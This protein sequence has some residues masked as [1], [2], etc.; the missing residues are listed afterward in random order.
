M[1]GSSMKKALAVILVVI[2]AFAFTTS[3]LASTVSVPLGAPTW[4][5]SNNPNNQLGWDSDGVDNKIHGLPFEVMAKATGLSISIANTPVDAGMQVV[6]ASDGGNWWDQQDWQIMDYFTPSDSGE[7]GRIFI[8]L[9]DHPGLATFR[10]GTQGRIVICYWSDSWNDLDILSA[11]LTGVPADTAE[12][13][14]VATTGAVTFVALAMG[15]LAVSGGGAVIVA[16]KLR[17]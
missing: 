11:S 17:K 9:S 15:V 2:M 3:A 14:G 7:G 13:A 4:R 10:S 6:L 12:D 8:P 1:G 16:R 5:D